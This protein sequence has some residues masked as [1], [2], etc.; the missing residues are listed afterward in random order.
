MQKKEDD[1]I[2]PLLEQIGMLLK[3]VQG[4]ASTSLDSPLDPTIKQRLELVED[5]IEQFREVTLRSLEEQGLNTKDI[6]NKIVDHPDQLKASDKELLR[7]STMLS[8]DT[9]V[10]RRALMSARTIGVKSQHFS[11]EFSEKKTSKKSIKQRQKKFK[12]MGGNSKWMPL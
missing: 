11:K 6:A 7:K 3:F 12:N 2:P 8:L 4:N 5:L 1:P 10:L 9:L